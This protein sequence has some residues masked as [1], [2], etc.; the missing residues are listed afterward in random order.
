MFTIKDYQ[1]KQTSQP[2]IATK[3]PKASSA[4]WACNAHQGRHGVNVLQASPQE[5][6]TPKKNTAAKHKF[7]AAPTDLTFLGKRT[8]Q[9]APPLLDDAKEICLHISSTKIPN[10]CFPCRDHKMAHVLGKLEHRYA[11][12]RNGCG[13]GCMNVNKSASWA[14]NA[15][16]GR[17]GANVLQASAHETHTPKKNTAAKHKSMVVPTDLTLLGKRF[18]SGLHPCWIMPRRFVLHIS[19]T[20]IPNH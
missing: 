12:E 19:S 13:D 3:L 14:C 1:G 8:A 10:P 2:T 7:M 9:R 4:L 16:Q 18:A 17:H 6:P 20:K 15:H 11:M 5:T